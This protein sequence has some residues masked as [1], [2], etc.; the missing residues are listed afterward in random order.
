MKFQARHSLS[1]KSYVIIGFIC[2]YFTFLFF[3][4]PWRPAFS[5]E[6]YVVGSLLK[7]KTRKLLLL[8]LIAKQ[9]SLTVVKAVC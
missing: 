8:L 2:V 3:F 1:N 9:W 4:K 6:L 7:N 5:F